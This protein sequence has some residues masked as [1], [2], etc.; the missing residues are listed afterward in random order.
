MI[1]EQKITDMISHELDQLMK[2]NHKPYYKR[3]IID[4]YSGRLMDKSAIEDR[5]DK[6]IQMIAR[7]VFVPDPITRDSC[8][9]IN[10]I[11][12][13]GRE[14][15]PASHGFERQRDVSTFIEP[16]RSKRRLLTIQ[17]MDAFER[18]GKRRIKA[19]AHKLLGLDE[20][21]ADY[22]SQLITIRGKM[23]GGNPLSPQI[24]NIQAYKID[25]YLTDFCNK[26]RLTY[27]R[28]LDSFAFSSNV[29]IHTEIVA[30]IKRT[31]S[32]CGWLID[33]E[34]VDI[35][36]GNH[37]H[38]GGQVIV[39]DHILEKRQKK[40]SVESGAINDLQPT[41]SMTRRTLGSILRDINPTAQI[42][43]EQDLIRSLKSKIS[44]NPSQ[45]EKK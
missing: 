38:I 34:L 14:P 5:E 33:N 36:S 9:R 43:K 16:H 28:Y 2:I 1:V 21:R 27:T 44:R 6:R 18:I 13:Y 25:R 11:L 26:Y 37:F 42:S 39:P 17:L 19:I 4:I 30:K 24:L 41:S 12:L 32:R 15:H 10:K 7:K 20:E 29:F 3:A 31:I 23:A 22:F 40:R 8:T 45:D 35:Q